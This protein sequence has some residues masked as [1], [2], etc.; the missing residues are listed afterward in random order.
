MTVMIAETAG[1]ISDYVPAGTLALV[2]DLAP[3][4]VQAKPARYCEGPLTCLDR[5]GRATFITDPAGH[6]IRCGA[7]LGAKGATRRAR[8]GIRYCSDEC[9]RRGR[10]ETRVTETADYARMARRVIT[11]LA[12]RGA[13]EF[14]Q[15]AEIAAVAKAADAALRAAVKGI[16][17]EHPDVSWAVIGDMLGI[18]RQ[19]AQ[20]R[21]GK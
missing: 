20:Q 16:R 7:I 15:L 21:F 1:Q 2:P 8:T 18:S 10:R 5:A 9:Q 12:E 13:T 3:V 4:K 19:G 14:D 6:V 17:V 11:K